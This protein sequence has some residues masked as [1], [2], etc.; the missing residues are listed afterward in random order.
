MGGAARRPDV[1]S[2]ALRLDGGVKR[3]SGLDAVVSDLRLEDAL[4]QSCAHDARR[5]FLSAMGRECAL[6]DEDCILACFQS[7]IAASMISLMA[8]GD[9]DSGEQV[10]PFLMDSI[11]A[12][13]QQEMTRSGWLDETDPQEMRDFKGL[14]FDAA[15]QAA[16]EN[17]LMK[18]TG[19]L[20]ECVRRVRAGL[21]H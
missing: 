7:L 4:L 5:T 17:S 6:D 19:L 13:I 16:Q 12:R 11:G 9:P 2:G 3:E 8:M 14:A 21:E 15:W 1:F 10:S 20:A 18:S